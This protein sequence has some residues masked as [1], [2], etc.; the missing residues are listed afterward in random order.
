M[1][2]A[3]TCLIF[4]LIA[5]CGET[6]LFAAIPWF[7]P[8]LFFLFPTLICLRWR[9]LETIYIYTFFGL[10]ADCFSTL[11]FGI[12]GLTFLLFSFF[13]RWY[14]IKIYQSDI[15][16][17]SIVIGIFSLL[18]DA[19]AFLLN[20]LFSEVKGI[21]IFWVKDVFFYKV[22]PTALLAIPSCKLLIY[23]ESRFRIHLAERKF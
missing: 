9:G 13:V 1:L 10:T 8:Y 2:P 14:S 7:N 19:L 16:I 21:S 22:L 17:L 11:S 6:F 5:I 4:W 12:F 18:S 23:L 3:I 20:T 15:I